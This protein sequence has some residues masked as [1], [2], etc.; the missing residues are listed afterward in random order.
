MFSPE[1]LHEILAHLKYVPE[2]TKENEVLYTKELLVE[3][4]VRGIL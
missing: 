3:I 1:K 2:R 4:L